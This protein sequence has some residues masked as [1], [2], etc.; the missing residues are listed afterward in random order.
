MDKK[1]IKK[2]VILG[3]LKK[4]LVLLILF[5]GT[6][7]I[8]AQEYKDGKYTKVFQSDKNADEIYQ[9]AKEWVAETFNSGKTVTDLD[10]KTKIIVKGKRQVTLPIMKNVS[11]AYLFNSIITISIKENKF[12]F[13]IYDTDITLDDGVS[14][15]TL[16]PSLFQSEK[17]WEEYVTYNRIQA[18]NT[19]LYRKATIRSIEKWIKNGKLKS[20]YETFYKKQTYLYKQ[21]IETL[22]TRIDEKINTENSEDDW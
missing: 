8:H 15:T 16:E 13:D 19:T 12:K 10:T 22:F 20:Q 21:S 11:H 18:Q 1:Q 9:L 14:P 2:F 7:N 17:S 6:T 3:A 4:M 5:F